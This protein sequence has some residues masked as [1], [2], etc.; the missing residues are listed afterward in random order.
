MFGIYSLNLLPD[1]ALFGRLEDGSW[2]FSI[3]YLVLT[4]SL[5]NDVH[6][7]CIC[8][9]KWSIASLLLAMHRSSSLTH[10]SSSLPHMTKCVDVCLGLCLGLAH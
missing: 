3:Q 2:F 6:V 7:Q 4:F 10:K 8:N 9:G 1:H 5:K